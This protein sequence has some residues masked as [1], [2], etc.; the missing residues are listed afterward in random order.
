MSSDDGLRKTE[1][2]EVP[3]DVDTDFDI[4]AAP[5]EEAQ[6]VEEQEP[7][8]ADIYAAP[9]EEA[10]AVEEQEPADADI[11][12]A[13]AEEAQA[14]EEQ[15]PADADI[16]AAPAEEAQAV[17]EQEPA[18]ADIYAAPAEEAQAVEEQEPA[19]ADIYAAPAEEAQAVE[20]QEP[21]DA[22]IYAAPAEEAQAVEE[23]EPAEDGVDAA[24][25]GAGSTPMLQARAETSDSPHAAAPVEE[26]G[27][28][29]EHED[30]AMTQ[31]GKL[32][33]EL[34]DSKKDE[35]G[36]VDAVAGADTAATHSSITTDDGVQVDAKVENAS[37]RAG[38]GVDN[39]EG[40]KGMDRSDQA[41]EDSA[42]PIP[43]AVAI[44]PPDA[45]AR[46]EM[47]VPP[48]AGTDLD[49]QDRAS[50]PETTAGLMKPSPPPHD[51]PRRQPQQQVCQPQSQQQQQ[52]AVVLHC[53]GTT[54]TPSMSPHAT[55]GGVDGVYDLPEAERIAMASA[56]LTPSTALVVFRRGHENSHVNRMD[57][58]SYSR[59][60][61]STDHVSPLVLEETFHGT[62]STV[63]AVPRN[64]LTRFS[65]GN[66]S[67]PYVDDSIAPR[68]AS[69]R[70]QS[71]GAA[72][73][74]ASSAR[75]SYQ[76]PRSVFSA[77]RQTMSD[78]FGGTAASSTN[79]RREIDM[80][81]DA[82]LPEVNTLRQ[83]RRRDPRHGK[84][85]AEQHDYIY[86]NHRSKGFY[87]PH[88]PPADTL[89]LQYNHLYGFGDG[90]RFAPVAPPPSRES[91]SA[92]ALAGMTVHRGNPHA[93]PPRTFAET[94]GCAFPFTASQRQHTYGGTAYR[95]SRI[96]AST[97]AMSSSSGHENQPQR[98]ETQ[99]GSSSLRTA[100]AV[101]LGQL[102][103]TQRSRQRTIEEVMADQPQRYLCGAEGVRG[104]LVQ[105]I[106]RDI[107]D[108][109]LQWEEVPPAMQKAMVSA[110]TTAAA[111]A[112]RKQ[113][114]PLVNVPAS[115]TLSASGRRPNRVESLAMAP[116]ALE[117]VMGQ[118]RAVPAITAASGGEP[119]ARG[120]AAAKIMS[121]APPSPAADAARATSPEP[122]TGSAAS[123]SR[124]ITV[125]SVAAAASLPAISRL[126]YTPQ[127][128]KR[129]N[130]SAFV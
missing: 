8:D 20:E 24:E 75:R 69:E 19:D 17:E 45:S 68:T 92:G 76:P 61:L 128:T 122:V 10:Q 40:E 97:R 51:L 14:V 47:A 18:D 12:A 115:S 1:Q 27:N 3:P 114:T 6:A 104:A 43:A 16:Y 79:L 78:S 60:L 82:H 36:S 74:A 90:T 100:K 55:T 87:V 26:V 49:K 2:V 9:A 46:V 57:R 88:D 53:S 99:K 116:S 108:G 66:V 112:Q 59:Y 105:D 4:Y 48:A 130:P 58:G 80:L 93:A 50:S 125:G 129:S 113:P 94:R 64:T 120:G 84:S 63:G 77:S 65:R 73:S 32:P 34:L 98:A 5:A 22:D 118:L 106:E 95:R 54:L 56:L 71:P 110:T 13:P 31:D 124:R 33:A 103:C 86:Y 117:N 121:T 28:T 42:A 126:N 81:G 67:D 39:N 37:D 70:K 30:A 62:K 7:A 23:Q 15:E 44:P 72:A 25:D 107:E 89:M 127:P 109:K 102:H 91:G 119:G 21:A 41:V 38:L 123:T 35:H 101:D 85:T 96:T 111:A 83:Q 52:P 29:S 11:Y